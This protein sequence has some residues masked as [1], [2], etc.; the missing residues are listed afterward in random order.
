M[1]RRS[2]RSSLSRGRCFSPIRSAR[3]ATFSTLQTRGLDFG[4]DKAYLA[5][6]RR[7]LEDPSG[8]WGEA[9]KEID[10]FTQPEQTLTLDTS[11]NIGNSSHSR[12][13]WFVGGELNTCWNAVDRHVANGI[14]DQAAIVWDSPVTN[15]KRVITYSELQN[16]VSALAAAL[17]ARGVQK[18]DA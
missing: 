11:I 14:G 16:Q 1:A 10:W 9:A 17:A 8:F 2:L 4:I 7:S 18:G 12:A 15:S 3:S 13:R 5:E 6:Y